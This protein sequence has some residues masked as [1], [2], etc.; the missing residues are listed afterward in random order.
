MS[1]SSRSA[2][3]VLMSA[4][5]KKTQSPSKSAKPKESS[6]RKR[7]TPAQ[8]L[9][10]NLIPDNGDSSAPAPASEQEENAKNSSSSQ[11]GDVHVE[12][13]MNAELKN[14]TGSGNA[15]TDNALVAAKKL[16]VSISP[17]ESVKELKKKAADFK[18]KRAA[19]WGEGDRVPFMFLAKALDA[20]SK[21]SG[22]IVIT[23]ITCNMLRTV[24]DTTPDDLLAVVYLS[25][26]RIASAHEGLELG[27][28]ETSII[29]A[30]AEACGAKET[31]IKKQYEVTE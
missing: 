18:V 16:K 6:P 25:A 7:K 23:E 4:S 21:E 5:K 13:P 15:D 3:D 9:T 19:Y 20:I 10:P 24:M 27:I 11:N 8:S 1:G 29:K 30:L 22:R 31:H 2:F 12:N 14:S 26:N 28:G 17:D